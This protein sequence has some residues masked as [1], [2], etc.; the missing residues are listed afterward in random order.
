MDILEV[1]YALAED[2]G[3]TKEE[4]LRIYDEKHENRGGFRDRLFL[5]SKDG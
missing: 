1:V 4:L 3:S 5:I 2:L